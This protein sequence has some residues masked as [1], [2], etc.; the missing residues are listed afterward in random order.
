MV[1]KK[2]SPENIVSSYKMQN[3][4]QTNTESTRRPICTIVDVKSL[5]SSDKKTNKLTPIQ[6]HM[7]NILKAHKLNDKTQIDQNVMKTEDSSVNEIEI[8]E[9]AIQDENESEE[10]GM[11][12][13]SGPSHQVSG[14]KQNTN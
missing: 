7:I 6:S 10:Q 9:Q 4:N 2:K 8:V 3:D 13:G 12:N 5:Q 14:K 11:F 1:R